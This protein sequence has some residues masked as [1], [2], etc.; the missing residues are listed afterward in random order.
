MTDGWAIAVVT[1]MTGVIV[2]LAKALYDHVKECRA[3]H[4]EL[5]KI[6]SA[7]TQIEQ[8]IGTRESGMRG[9]LHAQGHALAYHGGCVWMIAEK[10]GIKL[11]E[12]EK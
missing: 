12:R 3:V 5:A 8:H 1:V 9:A 10:L 11:P 2:G 4:T 7:I 6:A